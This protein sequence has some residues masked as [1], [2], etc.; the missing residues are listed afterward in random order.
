[1]NEIPEPALGGPAAEM[2]P[3]PAPGSGIW[4]S[5]RERAR[6]RPGTD[7]LPA[8]PSTSPTGAGT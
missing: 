2:V 5:G 3:A 7:G 8:A 6:P 1:M 4:R